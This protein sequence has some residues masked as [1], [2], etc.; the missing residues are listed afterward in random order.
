VED[1]A[2]GDT[3]AICEVANASL[4]D[5]DRFHGPMSPIEQLHG[6][7]AL[8]GDSKRRAY[9]EERFKHLGRTSLFAT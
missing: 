5:E 8:F 2:P 1:L 6:C 4:N 7:K 9:F 3:L